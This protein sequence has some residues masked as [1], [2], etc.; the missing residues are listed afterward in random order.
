MGIKGEAAGMDA[1]RRE[2]VAR[3]GTPGWPPNLGGQRRNPPGAATPATSG[4]GGSGTPASWDT[5]LLCGTGEPGGM[6]GGSVK[7][8]P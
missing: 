5:A 3:S 8:P 6:V 1:S 7:C 2:A 4:Q